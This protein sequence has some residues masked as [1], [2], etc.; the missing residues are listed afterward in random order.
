VLSTAEV[1]GF[2]RPRS[3][4]RGL[5]QE[6]VSG[7]ST[8]DVPAYSPDD[9]T[10]GDLAGGEAFRRQALRAAKHDDLFL[11]TL[12]VER[13]VSLVAE[14]EG[15]SVAQLRG[16]SRVRTLSKVRGLCAVVGRDLAQIPIAE[17]ARYFR[18]DQSTLSRDVKYLEENASDETRRRLEA[19]KRS[20]KRVG[21][22][23]T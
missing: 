8:L 2:F 1:L 21:G 19:L 18:R 13:L 12:T 22:S 4:A 3:N 15:V 16:P 17:T 9:A 10:F 11:R 14:N 7:G 5:F 6:F 23:N 20:V